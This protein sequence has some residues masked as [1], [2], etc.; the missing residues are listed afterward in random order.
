MLALCLDPSGLYAVVASPFIN[1]STL[2]IHKDK[3]L[4]AGNVNTQLEGSLSLS[5]AL[6]R[7]DR[8][9]TDRK[10]EILEKKINPGNRHVN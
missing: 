6:E 9:T 1:K 8:T 3:R 7:E 4:A 5:S 10:K 2:L